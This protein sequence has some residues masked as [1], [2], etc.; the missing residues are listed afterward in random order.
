M[1]S[2]SHLTAFTKEEIDRKIDSLAKRG[3]KYQEPKFMEWSKLWTADVVRD[4]PENPNIPFVYRRNKTWPS[5][6]ITYF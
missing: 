3:Y 2:T 5:N 4:I 6:P 1:K